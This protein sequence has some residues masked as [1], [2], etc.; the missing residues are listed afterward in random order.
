MIRVPAGES[1]RDIDAARQD[2]F[3]INEKNLFNNTWWLDPIFLGKY[4]E[5]GLALFEKELPPIAD[6]DMEIISQPLDF[7]GVNAY[8]GEPVRAGD[9]GQPQQATHPPG[10]PI[11]AFYWPVVP[12]ALYW[13]PKF[14]YERYN[15]PIYVTENGMSNLDWVSVDGGVHD[16]QRIDYT[17]RYLAQFQRAIA[18]GVDGRGYFHWSIMDNFEWADGFRQRFGLI[19]VDFATGK[20][21]IKDSARWYGD[22][23]RTNGESLGVTPSA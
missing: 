20:R 6:G 16:P 12:Q 22:V 10:H 18:D 7:F 19:Y 8:G 1:E 17:T 15:V 23:I 4:P 9:D 11:S 3:A 5:D 21:T 2:M 13:G 14:Y